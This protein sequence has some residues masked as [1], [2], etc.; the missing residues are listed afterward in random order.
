MCI[1][2]IT[3]ILD[4]VYFQSQLC[5]FNDHKWKIHFSEMKEDVGMSLHE[6]RR[7]TMMPIPRQEGIDNPIPTSLTCSCL[8]ILVMQFEYR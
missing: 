5:D 2:Y 1:L 6:K 8:W 7:G 4:A 3:L